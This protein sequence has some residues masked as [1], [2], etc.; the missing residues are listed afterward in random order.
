MSERLRN[1]GVPGMVPSPLGE[2]ARVRGMINDPL[3]PAY[4]EMFDLLLSPLLGK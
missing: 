1:F 3:T 4:D 2:R